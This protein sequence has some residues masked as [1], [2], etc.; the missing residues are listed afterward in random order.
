MAKLSVEGRRE[1]VGAECACKSDERPR[2][3]ECE[4]N[5]CDRDDG[6]S[7]SDMCVQWHNTT[8]DGVKRAADFKVVTRALASQLT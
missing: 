8:V 1:P 5:L 6:E 2:Q 7:S 4:H 3:Q